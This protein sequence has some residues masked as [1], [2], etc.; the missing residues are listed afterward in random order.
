MTTDSNRPKRRVELGPAGDVVRSNVARIRKAR[1]LTLRGMATQLTE[2]G[3]PLAHTAISDIENGS[4]RVDADDLVALALA[5]DVAPTTLL[6]PQSDDWET[7]S[8]QLTE[9]VASAPQ[10]VWEWL[11]AAYPLK[12]DTRG[13]EPTRATLEFRMRARPADAD[14]MSQL[15]FSP[16]GRERRNH[17]Q[18]PPQPVEW[19][20]PE[21]ND[22]NG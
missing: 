2:V 3:R 1:G 15:G 7:G 9:N 20:A 17:Q 21:D 18:N 5:L 22:G 6:M 12:R 4:R 14:L 16:E 10:R 11:I 19:I 13:N 8:V